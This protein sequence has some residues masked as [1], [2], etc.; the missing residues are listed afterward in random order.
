MK[1]Q[2]ILKC[3]GMLIVALALVACNDDDDSS[4]PAAKR[5]V[6][7][8]IESIING[9]TPHDTTFYVYDVQGRPTQFKELSYVKGQLI[10]TNNTYTY[11]DGK[12]IVN[13]TSEFPR[14]IKLDEHNRIV[15]YTRYNHA[16]MAYYTK[17][18]TYDADGQLATSVDG[19]ETY[20]YKWENGDL[21]G[22]ECTHNG[23]LLSTNTIV[24]SAIE[25]TECPPNIS[26][27]GIDAL[28]YARGYFG[29]LS[30]HLPA[31]QVLKTNETPK[32]NIT[33]TQNF[34]YKLVDGRVAEYTMSGTVD[35]N[36]LGM[37]IKKEVTNTCYLTWKEL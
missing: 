7:S 29:K 16:D 22:Y 10:I 19:E 36:M 3:T 11:A 1:R 25:C 15:E 5:Y 13:D 21:V 28:F 33:T 6:V 30:K 18:Y 2:D 20:T 8:Q 31:S 35:M 24:P 23:E 37:S 27:Y 4:T 9:E 26:V 17:T 32:S 34:T 12:I 14:R